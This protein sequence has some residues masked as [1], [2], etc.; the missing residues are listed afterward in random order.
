MK[1]EKASEQYF[2]KYY[3]KRAPSTFLTSTSSEL[4]HPHLPWNNWC[5]QC[6]PEGT[7]GS[8]SALWIIKEWFTA[9]WVVFLL[10]VFYCILIP[11]KIGNT[12][13]TGTRGLQPRARSHH[14]GVGSFFGVQAGSHPR[15]FHPFH[16]AAS[17]EAGIAAQGICRNSSL[18]RFLCNSSLPYFPAQLAGWSPRRNTIL[19]SH[20]LPVPTRRRARNSGWH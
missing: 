18:L 13:M 4:A 12:P 3:K 10:S 15:V 11:L 1:I 7:I 16:P 5:L 8:Q 14:W 20:P 2:S 17:E 19:H 6:W 9:F